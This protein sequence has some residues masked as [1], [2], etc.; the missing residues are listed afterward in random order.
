MQLQLPSASS[1]FKTG[2]L[3]PISQLSQQRHLFSHTAPKKR[4]AAHSKTAAASRLKL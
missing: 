4:K 3:T 2:Y 1:G